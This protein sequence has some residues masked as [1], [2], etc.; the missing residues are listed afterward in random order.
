MKTMKPLLV[1][2]LALLLSLPG[3]LLAAETAG[4]I[5]L[6]TGRATAA[7]MDGNIRGLA[8]NGNVYAGEVINTGPNS[9]LNVKFTDGG[10]ILLRPNTRFQIEAYKTTP[11]VVDPA[12]RANARSGRSGQAVESEEESNA[13]FRLLKGGF[14]AIT[15][16]I[17]REN[18]DRYKVRTPVATIGIRGTDF[19]VRLCAGDCVD[20]TPPPADGLYAGVFDGGIVTVN[21]AGSVDT[22]A[23]QYS[24]T[25]NASSPGQRLPRRPRVLAQD[26]MPDPENCG[27]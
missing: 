18:K 5:T 8:K 24:F 27:E 21:G 26:P 20:V 4:R 19:E 12:E 6:L 10:R 25:P 17:G 11:A 15:G 9:Y 16:L 2:S 3:S 23:G 14:R 1:L 13:V 22:D 7:D